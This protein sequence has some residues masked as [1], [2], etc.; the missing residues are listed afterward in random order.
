MFCPNC[1][2]DCG[3]ARFCVRCGAKVEAKM[4][5]TWFPGI[6][7]PFCGG[8][9]QEN[10]VCL[11]CGA[12]L[13]E[14]SSDPPSKLPPVPEWMIG[15]RYDNKGLGHCFEMTKDYVRFLSKGPRTSE[16]DYIIPL[17]EVYAVKCT[18]KIGIWSGWIC[19][20]SWGDM[21]LPFPKGLGT[22][23]DPAC[24]HFPDAYLPYFQSVCAFLEHCAKINWEERQKQKI[25]LP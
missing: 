2:N 21:Y 4:P 13:T 18:K 1:G 11:F 5:T 24:F 17:D 20:R 25:V 8:T 7:C 23:T 14:V 10:G 3:N 6:P 22:A 12:H 19:V 16:R 9:Q 15:K